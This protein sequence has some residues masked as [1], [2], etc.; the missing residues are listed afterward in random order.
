MAQLMFEGSL[1]IPR[2][3]MSSIF[4]GQLV[5]PPQNKAQTSNQNSRVIWVLGISNLKDLLKLGYRW[6]LFTF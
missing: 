3:P 2:A 5:N 4:E 6:D 1:Y